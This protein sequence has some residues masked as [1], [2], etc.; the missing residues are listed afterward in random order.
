MKIKN[1]KSMWNIIAAEISII[2]S[3]NISYKNCENRWKVL[4]RNYKKWVDNQN[5][6][7]RGRKFFEFAEEM[8]SVYGK[9][10]SVHPELCLATETQHFPTH[11]IEDAGTENV[12]QIHTAVVDE[13]QK[14]PVSTKGEAIRRKILKKRKSVLEQIREDRLKFQEKRLKFLEE[15]HD[16]TI[17]VLQE[18]NKIENERNDILR[19]KKCSCTCRDE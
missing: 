16:K 15:A 19:E 6:T 18:R 9:K 13:N 4:D 12:P 10:K 7:G 8:N 1:I 5:S 17:S 11:E 2:L 3:S 14:E